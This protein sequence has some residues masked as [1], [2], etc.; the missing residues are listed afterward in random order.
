MALTLDILDLLSAQHWVWL[1]GREKGK[2]QNYKK[3]VPTQEAHSVF[4]GLGET[5]LQEAK[6]AI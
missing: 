6:V 4:I 3:H 2:E 1:D 5:N